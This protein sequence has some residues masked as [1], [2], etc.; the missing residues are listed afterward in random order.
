MKHVNKI[1]SFIALFSVL[2]LTFADSTYS[3]MYVF[4]DSLSDTG[5]LASIELGKQNDP[6]VPLSP[7][8][9]AALSLPPYF[10]FRFSNGPVSVDV[11]AE[12]LGPGLDARAYLDYDAQTGEL[13][14]SNYAV[15]GARARDKHDDD[16]PIDLGDQVARFVQTHSLFGGVPDNALYV[17]MI[18]SNDVRDARDEYMSSNY[19]NAKIIIDEAIDSISDALN[20]L[21]T[22]GAKAIYVINAPDIGF[23]PETLLYNSKKERHRASK[24]TKRFNRKLEHAVNR[25]ERETELQIIVFDLFEFGKALRKNNIALELP[26]IE[27]ACYVDLSPLIGYFGGDVCSNDAGGLIRNYAYFD[28]LHPTAFVHNRI[29][30]A[31]FA[32]VP[33][34]E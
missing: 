24:L 7:L 34:F 19:H 11:L 1:L 28:I 31:M 18:G 4:G 20:V 2:P 22:Q 9:D 8:P 13:P 26:N 25:F 33:T 16:E 3:K 23:I 29:G 6:P 30:R 17:I 21:Y 15:A 32:L 14:G 27:G 10:D 12:L 5:N